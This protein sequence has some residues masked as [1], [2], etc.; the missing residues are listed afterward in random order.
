MEWPF[1]SF[2]ALPLRGHK[3]LNTLL[4][5]ILHTTFSVKQGGWR[6]L[7]SE[8]STSSKVLYQTTGII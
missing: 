1:K 2:L 4:R 6:Y 8:D 7:V 5:L 3:A